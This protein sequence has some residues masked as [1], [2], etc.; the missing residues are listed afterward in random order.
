MVAD[1][2]R[3]APSEQN[4]PHGAEMEP[5][6][7]TGKIRENSHILL[8]SVLQRKK[9]KAYVEEI[10]LGVLNSLHW[11]HRKSLYEVGHKEI[12]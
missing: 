4:M 7:D 12:R 5:G 6:Q 1:L 11:L 8:Y 2:S 9:D 10:L 3:P